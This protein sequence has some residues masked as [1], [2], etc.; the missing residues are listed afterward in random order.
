MKDN[1]LVYGHDS[2]FFPLIT[3]RIKRVLLYS[4]IWLFGASVILAIPLAI[5]MLIGK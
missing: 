1:G 5:S 2:D 3:R 4:V